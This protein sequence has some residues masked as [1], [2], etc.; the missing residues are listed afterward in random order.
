MERLFSAPDGGYFLTG[1]DGESLVVRP[2][3]L[4]DG[5]IPASG[6]AAAAALA[7]LG[8]ITGEERYL[9]RAVRAVTASGAAFRE[10]P[11][12]LPHLIGAALT[13]ES[14][15]LEIVIAGQRPD[16]VDAVAPRYL[17]ESVLL[18]GEPTSGPLW[19]G[20]DDDRAYVCR[21]GV[22]L[23]PVSSP[24]D[25]LRSIERARRISA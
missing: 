21:A 23:A 7:R 19:E 13:I 25:L 2:R 18:W 11:M 5:V 4:Y 17:P 16:L 14:G 6:S 10:G 3:D 15:A 12:A 9:A 1:A 20:R 8:A 22:C 24:T